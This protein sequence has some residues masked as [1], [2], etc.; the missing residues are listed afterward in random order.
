MATIVERLMIM[1]CF[2]GTVGEHKLKLG[3]RWQIY[4]YK[5]N[6]GVMSYLGGLILTPPPPPQI[7]R[8]HAMDNTTQNLVKVPPYSLRL[9]RAVLN[10]PIDRVAL[11]WSVQRSGVTNKFRPIMARGEYNRDKK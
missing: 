8:H 6:L 11:L 1:Q 5:Q 2:Q 10:S 9:F 4:L 7:N 3:I